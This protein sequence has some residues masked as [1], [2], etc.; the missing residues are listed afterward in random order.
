MKQ[1]CCFHFFLA[2]FY[3]PMSNSPNTKYFLFALLFCCIAS[4]CDVRAHVS[5]KVTYPDGTPL[6]IGAVQGYDESGTHIRG[7]I[8]EDGS[9]ELYEV[10]P[11]DRV[12]AGKTYTIFIANAEV[13]PEAAPISPG[14]MFPPSIPPK[15][16]VASRFSNPSLSELRLEVPKSS[17]PVEFNIEVTKP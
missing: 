8:G 13:R 15:E 17:K 16:L 12:P 4:G 1:V 10:K 14:G 7:M 11:G 6:N 2:I 5:G 9:F 3:T